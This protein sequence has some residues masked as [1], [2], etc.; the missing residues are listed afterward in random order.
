MILG[1]V[2]L[3]ATTETL[4]FSVD[5]A[6]TIQQISFANRNAG[7]VLLRLWIVPRDTAKADKHIWVPDK[8]LAAKSVVLLF[9]HNIDLEQGEQIWAYS[10]TANVSVNVVGY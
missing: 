10:D 5:Q 8:N 2:D 9:E 3:A 4:V 7:H 6:R 1:S